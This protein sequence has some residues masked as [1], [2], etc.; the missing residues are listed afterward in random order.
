VCLRERGITLTRDGPGLAGR[1]LDIKFLG[2]VARLEVGVEGFDR[3]LKVRV[4]ELDGWGRGAEVHVEIDADRA[5]V[6]PAE[7]RESEAPVTG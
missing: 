1:V 4:R 6:F 5:L 2:D 7:K 3:P